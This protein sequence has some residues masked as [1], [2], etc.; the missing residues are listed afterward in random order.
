[1]RPNRM[2]FRIEI[3]SGIGI[4]GNAS[5]FAYYRNSSMK[6]ISFAFLFVLLSPAWAFAHSVG[7]D[8]GILAGLSHPV[9]GFDHLLAMVS[10]GILSAQMGGRAVWTV[11][12]TF[13][14]VM[15][16]GGLLGMAGIPLISVEIGIAFSVLALGIALAA[17]KKLPAFVAMGFVGFFAVFHGHAHGTEMPHLAQPALYVMGFLMGTVGLH[18]WGVMIGLFASR[19]DRG[20]SFLRYLGAGISG[21]GFHLLIL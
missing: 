20:S 4:E 9:L 15:L 21:I 8:G 5:T 2:R 12:A 13:V 17:G 19:S 14:T 10:V 6:K 3:R 7:G 11:P 18:L 16:I 1:M